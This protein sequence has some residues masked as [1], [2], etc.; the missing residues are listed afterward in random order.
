M[1][2]ALFIA[3]IVVLMIANVLVFSNVVALFFTA[4]SE[5]FSRVTATRAPGVDVVTPVATTVPPTP[6]PVPTLT[7][8]PTLP[9]PSATPTNGPTATPSPTA[10]RSLTGIPVCAANAPFKYP[11][12]YTVK[13]GDAL[14]ILANRF[15]VTPTKI[16][17]ANGI[18]DPDLIR[19]GEILLIP[20]P[21]Q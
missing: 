21:N 11:C 13:S 20:D 14:T 17:A 8:T 10:T 3:A 7:A 2:R 9:T 5:A 4:G 12:V 6:T 18:S 16:M 1:S 15:K 19:I